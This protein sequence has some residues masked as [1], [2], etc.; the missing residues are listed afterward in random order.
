MSSE[1]SKEFFFSQAEFDRQQAT[2]NRIYTN[3]G[4]CYDR[5]HN[6][7]GSVRSGERLFEVMESFLSKGR[8]SI[9]G[10]D[11]IQD[12]DGLISFIF[13]N[14]GSS[15][16][17]A[18]INL[19]LSAG[20]LV[21]SVRALRNK[22]WGAVWE[23]L[24]HSA[25]Y[26]GVGQALSGVDAKTFGEIG[27]I[28]RSEVAAKNAAK[29]HGPTNEM[30]DWAYSFVREYNGGFGNMRIAVEA[31]QPLLHERFGDRFEKLADDYGTVYT[32][33][34]KMPDKAKYFRSVKKD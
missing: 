9:A 30:R 26:C 8:G 7:W 33:L 11:G 31:L 10:S 27:K 4:E 21:E 28:F 5:L 22:H 3:L 25:Y 12:I 24:A 32:W 6:K 14:E 29:L 15:I 13:E 23:C 1:A 19:Y 2:A 34:R 17:T 20:F 18:T 16:D